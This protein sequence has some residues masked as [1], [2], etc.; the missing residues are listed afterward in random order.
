MK[1]LASEIQRENHSLTGKAMITLE[2]PD[3]M[4]RPLPKNSSVVWR[5]STFTILG[6]ERFC[7]GGAT[8]FPGEKFAVVL[9]STDA[10]PAGAEINILA[11]PSQDRAAGSE[12]QRQA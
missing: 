7:H 8:F 9:D 4:P 10:P 3:W 5:G 1:V 12:T 6:V 11:L 2:S